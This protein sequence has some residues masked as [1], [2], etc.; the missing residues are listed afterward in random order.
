MWRGNFSLFSLSLSLFPGPPP[1]R[2][3]DD[4]APTYSPLFPLNY[5]EIVLTACKVIFPFASFTSLPFILNHSVIES[6]AC[7]FL[8]AHKH[9]G[10]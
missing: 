1:S 7:S 2:L 6:R 5:L 9:T 8:L 10:C 4:S 3:I